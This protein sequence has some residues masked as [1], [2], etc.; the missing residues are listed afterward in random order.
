[1]TRRSFLKGL[2]TLMSIP[3]FCKVLGRSQS[4][5]RVAKIRISSGH[6]LQVGEWIT[7]VDT[8]TPTAEHLLKIGSV[9]DNE[10]TVEIV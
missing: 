9:A 8:N 7:L 5:S 4:K 2:A 10:I 1:M 6:E 3:A